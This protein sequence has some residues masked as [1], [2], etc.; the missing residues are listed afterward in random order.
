M[1]ACEPAC[2]REPY[3]TSDMSWHDKTDQTD[4]MFF[5][6]AQV[7]MPDV[8]NETGVK[9]RVP[10]EGSEEASQSVP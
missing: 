6:A 1:L 7:A 4:K 2:C 3:C 5:A 9:S 8:S 10:R